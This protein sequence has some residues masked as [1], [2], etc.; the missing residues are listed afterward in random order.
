MDVWRTIHRRHLVETTGSLVA[1]KRRQTTRDDFPVNNKIR[2]N[3]PEHH[4]D[5]RKGSSSLNANI[6]SKNVEGDPGLPH[7]TKGLPLIFLEGIQSH[8][9]ARTSTMFISSERYMRMTN[10]PGHNGALLVYVN[11]TLEGPLERGLSRD[12]C[13]K[14]GC[15]EFKLRSRC[16]RWNLL[17]VGGHDS[18]DSRVL[19]GFW[20]EV[21]GGIP[22]RGSGPFDAFHA[23]GSSP[24]FVSVALGKSLHDTK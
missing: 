7:R 18:D 24:C 9:H 2:V 10:A 20:E 12:D 19:F 13:A 6:D 15:R 21:P 17:S 4:A 5:L 1:S 23:A 16:N 8:R 3:Q 11:R 14:L 22:F